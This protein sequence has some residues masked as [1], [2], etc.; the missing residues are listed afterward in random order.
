MQST[1]GVGDWE[2]LMAHQ[3]SPSSAYSVAL[4]T[5]KT[6]APNHQEWSW[7]PWEETLLSPVP[8]GCCKTVQ[9]IYHTPKYTNTQMRSCDSSLQQALIR[10]CSWALLLLS[11]CDWC[12]ASLALTNA[13]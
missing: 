9:L 6:S 4:S 8:P 13:D 11:P 1:G 12:L 2:E 7:E 5:Q 10:L 3:S